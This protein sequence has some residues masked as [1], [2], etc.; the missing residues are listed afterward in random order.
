M[1][2]TFSDL[3]SQIEIL[4]SKN[5]TILDEQKAIDILARHNYYIVIN[6]YRKPFLDKTKSEERSRYIDG[7]TFEEIYALYSFDRNIRIIFL[8]YI[9]MLEQNFKSAISYEFSKLYGHENYLTYENF[10]Y[11]NEKN[12]RDIFF[13][14][15]SVHNALSKAIGKNDYITYNIEKY[16]NVPFWILTNVIT[17]GGIINFYKVMKEQEKEYIAKKYF[18]I[19]ADDLETFMEIVSSFRN[20]CAHDERLYDTISKTSIP[21]NE[22]LDYFNQQL[23]C[24]VNK[25]SVF[26]LLIGLCCLLSSSD[27]NDL[28]DELERE[29]DILENK[30]KSITIDAIYQIT[31]FNKHWTRIKNI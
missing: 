6:G 18:R 11:E 21:D 1:K 25:K 12:I 9:L 15:G 22:I 17:L 7:S 31:G 28:V 16:N 19:R 4:K 14:I 13:T 5:L 27:S 29:F 2:K 8:K 23:R 20:I 3:Y 24:S 26:S 30:L 10:A